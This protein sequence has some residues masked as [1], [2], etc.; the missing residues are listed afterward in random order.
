MKILVIGG[1]GHVGSFLVPMLLEQGHEVYVATRGNTR[2]RMGA[3]FEGAK[4]VTCNAREPETLLPLRDYHFD[5]IAEFPGKAYNV[6]NVFKDNVDHIVACGSV[7]MYGYPHVVPTPEVYQDKCLFGGYDVR[8]PEIREMIAQSGTEKAVFTAIMVPNICGPGKVPLDQMCGRSVERHKAMQRGET[9]I[10]PDGPE[11]LIGPCDA[12]D[13][14]SLFALAI[15]NRTAAA[16]QIFNAGSADAVTGTQLIRLFSDIYEVEIPI[17]RVPWEIYKTEV[18]PDM[19]NWWHFYAHMLPDISK[20]RK[21]LGYEPKYSVKDTIRRAVNWMREE[22][23][24]N[25]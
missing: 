25:D 18:N 11:A 8:Y 22:G 7:W 16:G 17:E 24:L 5:A 12:E 4:Y 23:L 13:L 21:L 20:A 9:V 19:G 3:A 1:T 10:L 15:N 14:A 6:W 2:P